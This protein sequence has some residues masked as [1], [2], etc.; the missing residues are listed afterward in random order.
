MGQLLGRLV[1]GRI[2][3]FD[4]GVIALPLR[5][6]GGW[7]CEGDALCIEVPARRRVRRANAELIL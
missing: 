2:E 7:R 1:G 6:Y 4:G 5:G 3:W